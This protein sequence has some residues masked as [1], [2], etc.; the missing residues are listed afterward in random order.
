M[1]KQ[2][3]LPR[4]ALVA[5]VTNITPPPPFPCPKDSHLVLAQLVDNGFV[6]CHVLLDSLVHGL[7][8]LVYAVAR[9]RR[10]A[11]G[12]KILVKLLQD[13]GHGAG[14]R[15][16]VRGL[17]GHGLV[18]RVKVLH[19]LL[20]KLARDDVRLVE[21]QHKG[22][23]RLVED[24][25]GIQ[26]VAHKGNGTGTTRGVQDIDDDGRKA[27]RQRLCDDGTRRRPRKDFNLPGGVE[28]HVLVLRRPLLK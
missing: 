14:E 17:V 28:E 6:I 5:A 26:H 2:A 4:K 22:E 11:D 16:N 20:G 12:A 7:E 24:A 10:H 15:G 3:Q 19:P 13:D 27:G 21:G 18:K 1:G 23:T 25:A 8:K 9:K